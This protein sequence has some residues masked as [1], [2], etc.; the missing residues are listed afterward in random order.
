[1]GFRGTGNELSNRITAGVGPTLSSASAGNDTLVGNDGDDSLS[2]GEGGDS[3]N[4]GAGNDTLDGG[5]GNDTFDGGAGD[6]TY[7]VEAS[8]EPVR[9][10]PEGTD[11]IRTSAPSYSLAGLSS[12]EHLVYVGTG[13]FAGTGSGLANSI[14]GGAGNDTLDGLA[15]ADTLV[16]LGGNDTY[17]VRA[18]TNVVEAAGGGTDTVTTYMM[19]FTLGTNVEN[20]GF[21]E[22]VGERPAV[23][24]LPARGTSLRTSIGGGI[25]N[26][27]LLGLA[28]RDTLSGYAGDDRL[29][30]GAG[31][32]NMRGGAGNDT[33]IVDDAGDSDRRSGRRLTS[34]SPHSASTVFPTRSMSRT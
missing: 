33:Y 17:V 27:T 20:L 7:I 12:I 13:S 19:S 32:D 22:T 29:D 14:T 24:P 34:F 21:L 23:R 4:G 3:L 2:G 31:A 25:G 15:G 11:T 10:D 16:G 18:E 5:A 28:G 1:M 9:I 30:G 26:D 8:S 6:D